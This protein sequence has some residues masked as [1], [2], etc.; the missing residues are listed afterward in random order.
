MVKNSKLKSNVKTKEVQ[1]K[2]QKNGISKRV[3]PVK[4]APKYY[5][6]EDVPVRTKGAAS[7]AGKLRSSITPGTVLI[8]LSGKRFAGRR[9]VFLKQLPSG[10]ALVTGPYKVNGVPLRRVNQ[11]YVI[12]TSTKVD[13]A[14]AAKAA[15]GIDD[16]FF[17]H[18]EQEG[19]GGQF[20]DKGEEKKTQ[21]SEARKNKQKEVDASLLSAIKKVPNLKEYLS[22][23]FTLTHGQYPHEMK[24]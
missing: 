9:V 4:R 7:K 8:L 2:A 1:V 11:A 13:A 19:E 20:F 3:V 12:S 14:A 21:V 6:T 15:A 17:A 16:D 18:E 22:S 10:M 24:F 23:T 5:P